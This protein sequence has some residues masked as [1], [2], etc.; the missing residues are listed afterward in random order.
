M[1]SGVVWIGPRSSARR[2][3][4]PRSTNMVDSNRCQGKSH[5]GETQQSVSANVTANATAIATDK[6]VLW[7]LITKT[8]TT[9][10][11]HTHIHTH[12]HTHTDRP[13]PAN[14]VL[15]FFCGKLLYEKDLCW[16]FT[17]AVSHRARAFDVSDKQCSLHGEI[18]ENISL[19]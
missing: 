8:T 11:I 14:N 13:R 7:S 10:I 5:V 17:E 18:T 3:L 15:I 9:T 16:F 1:F 2:S 19:W 12:A 6:P 4:L